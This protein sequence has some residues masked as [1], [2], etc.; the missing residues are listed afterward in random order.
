MPSQWRLRR[1]RA[2]GLCTECTRYVPEEG[3]ALCPRCLETKRIHH[4]KPESERVRRCS[5]VN[6]RLLRA[7]ARALIAAQLAGEPPPPPPTL[8]E[9]VQPRWYYVNRKQ[10]WRRRPGKIRKRYKYTPRPLPKPAVSVLECSGS[11]TSEVV[12]CVP[13]GPPSVP[14][15]LA[16]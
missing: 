3:R 15:P 9:W 11:S 16:P 7:H 2:L 13:C 1:S 14:D 8:V 6:N 12:E 4:T 10:P 5:A